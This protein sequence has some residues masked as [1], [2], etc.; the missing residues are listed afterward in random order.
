MVRIHRADG[1]EEPVNV[2]IIHER[3]Q[4]LLRCAVEQSFPH[5]VTV[6]DLLK[7]G[8]SLC[9]S[10]NESTSVNADDDFSEDDRDAESTPN[11]SA[12]PAKRP[13]NHITMPSYPGKHVAALCMSAVYDIF[14]QCHYSRH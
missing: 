6:D 13:R 10:S 2:H 7:S 11:P 14:R 5:A 1:A 3:R 8:T 9:S 12:P 4:D